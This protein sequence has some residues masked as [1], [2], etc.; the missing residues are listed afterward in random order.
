M[1]TPQNLNVMFN[2][3]RKKVTPTKQHIL[4]KQ[5]LKER[6]RET[7]YRKIGDKVRTIQGWPFTLP[8]KVNKA[9]I[10]NDLN[11]RHCKCKKVIK[12]D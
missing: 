2:N 10:N 1:T 12:D 6:Q 3:K 8:T 7:G 5:H 11:L 4:S 9:R